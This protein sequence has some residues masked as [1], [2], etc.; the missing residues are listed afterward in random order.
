MTKP[1]QELAALIIIGGTV[2]LMV[3]CWLVVIFLDDNIN[4][5]P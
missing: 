3:V 2:A 5:K 1:D 4:P